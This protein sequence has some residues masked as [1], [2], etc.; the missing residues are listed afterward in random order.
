[1]TLEPWQLVVAV[2]TSLGG[3]AM[4]VRLALRAWSR[5]Q[6]QQL[7]R[8][9]EQLERWWQVIGELPAEVLSLSLRCMLG[10]VMYQR[11]KRARRIRADHPFL[12]SQQLQIARFIGRTPREDGRRLTGAAREQALGAVAQLEA[13]LAQSVADGL[14]SR[15]ERERCE[16]TVFEALTTLEVAHCR[17]AALQAE[18]LRRLPQAVA[19]LRSALRAAETLGPDF[20]DRARIADRLARL[21]GELAAQRA[22]PTPAAGPG[23]DALTPPLAAAVPLQAAS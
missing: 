5:R 21:E 4:A 20:P 1:M 10:R 19:Y 7:M 22:R 15:A 11:L 3:S 23:P 6:L 17:Q 18:Y 13:L 16:T 14:T 2:S 12:Q 9:S 8:D